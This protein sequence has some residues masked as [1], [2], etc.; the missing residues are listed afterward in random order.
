MA[1]D[2]SRS[3]LWI[4]C[5]PCIHTWIAAYLP[6]E[7]GKIAKLMKRLRCPKC[8]IGGKRLFMAKESDIKIASHHNAA[9]AGRI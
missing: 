5:G 6:M 8:G 3:E 4:T 1:D 9:A 7:M 2:P